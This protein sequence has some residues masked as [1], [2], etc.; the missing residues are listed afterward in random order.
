MKLKDKVAFITGAGSGIGKQTAILFAEQGATV[1][2]ADLDDSAAQEVVKTIS[3]S[4]AKGRAF[5]IDVSVQDHCKTAVEE[6]VD[7]F[8]GIDI[9]VNNAGMPMAKGIDDLTEEDW[10]RTMAVNMKSVFFCTKLVVPSM[11]E[12]G[13]GAIVSTSSVTGLIGSRGQSAYCVSKAGI[14]CFTQCMA[15]EL[16]PFNIRVNAICP[17]FTDTPMLRRFLGDWFPDKEE[18]EAFIGDTKAKAALNCYGTPLDM[19]QAIL[20][21]AS[22]DAAFITGQALPVDGGTA[23]NI[24]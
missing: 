11:R 23:I 5:G 20:F 18:R 3:G 13:G 9:L 16:A 8:G 2:A 24:L 1:A 12:R 21:L 17:G 10:D 19:A 14:I 22:E 6:T 15:L 7:A 4:G